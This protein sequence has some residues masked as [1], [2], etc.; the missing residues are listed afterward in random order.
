MEWQCHTPFMKTTLVLWS[1]NA[2]PS[3][4]RNL[5]LKLSSRYFFFFGGGQIIPKKIFLTIFSCLFWAIWW[6]FLGIFGTLGPASPRPGGPA[7]GPLT[8]SDP[9]MG[10]LKFRWLDI[11]EFAWLHAGASG[12]DGKNHAKFKISIFLSSHCGRALREHRQCTKCR[13]CITS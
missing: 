4:N 6:N 7:G 12:F 2:I 1:G 3:L 13:C 8:T 10:F 9:W 11:L 5:L